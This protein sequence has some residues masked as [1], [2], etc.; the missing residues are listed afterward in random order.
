MGADTGLL[1]I[2][3]VSCNAGW[4]VGRDSTCPAVQEC[5]GVD[6]FHVTD[7]GWVHD[8]YFPAQCAEGLTGS[9]MSIYTAATFVPSFCAGDR[10]RP[11]SS[12]PTR[13]ASASS[14]CRPH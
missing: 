10:G 2:T 9:G 6:V 5:D 11:R 12:G 14:S 1:T 13:W 7:A 8:G 3:G 4:A